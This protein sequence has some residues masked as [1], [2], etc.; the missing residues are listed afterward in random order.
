LPTPDHSFCRL[1]ISKKKRERGRRRKRGDERV[2]SSNFKWN[3][4]IGR[5]RANGVPMFLLKGEEVGDGEEEGLVKC[6]EGER[7]RERER[8]RESGSGRRIKW[9][10]SLKSAGKSCKVRATTS[11]SGL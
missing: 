1:W 4:M 8:E 2:E 9:S 10:E 11:E 3:K 5:L 6:K 7:E